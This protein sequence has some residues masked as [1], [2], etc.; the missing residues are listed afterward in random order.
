[1][2]D[3]TG[4][5]VNKTQN[6]SSP[7][8]LTRCSYSESE[9]ADILV[10]LVI[11]NIVLQYEHKAVC[12]HPT[13]VRFGRVFMIHSKRKKLHNTLWNFYQIYVLNN[14]NNQFIPGNCPVSKFCVGVTYRKQNYPLKNLS[15]ILCTK[16]CIILVQITW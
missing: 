3:Y 9:A 15:P 8:N 6:L 7:S 10:F 14:L 13:T 12:P 4:M 11:N 2:Q 1:L 16:N 5:Q